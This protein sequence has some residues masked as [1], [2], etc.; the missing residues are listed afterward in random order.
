MFQIQP[1]DLETQAVQVDPIDISLAMTDVRRGRIAAQRVDISQAD[2]IQQ[3]LMEL[4]FHWLPLGGIGFRGRLASKGI[5]DKLII[6]DRI[7]PL[8]Q[9][10]GPEIAE[11]YLFNIQV[12]MQK[13]QHLEPY[14]DQSC[15]KQG[16]AVS[17]L[18]VNILQRHRP[19]KGDIQMADADPRLEFAGE[20]FFGFGPGK[21]LDKGGL[22]K[23]K[24]QKQ[25]EKQGEKRL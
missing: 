2:A 15:R 17:V 7:S 12:I 5:D 20:V 18:N 25:D 6:E 10:L 4:Y 3:Q 8:P 13:T 21:I 14:V 16:I 19:E 23:K 22:N 1:R 11:M 9:H 24:D